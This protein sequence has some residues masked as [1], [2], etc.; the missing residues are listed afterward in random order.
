MDLEHKLGITI[1][2]ELV[3]EALV[4]SFSFMISLE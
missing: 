1:K 3:K 4:E 2:P